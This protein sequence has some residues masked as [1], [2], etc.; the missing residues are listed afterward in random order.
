MQW[1]S[2]IVSVLSLLVSAG[3]LHLARLAFFRSG[4]LLRLRF[5]QNARELGLMLTETIEKLTSTR[6]S[7]QH[8]LAMIGLGRSGNAQIF[9]QEANADDAEL[10]QLRDKG[11]SRIRRA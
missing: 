4:A 3:S 1:A 7:H 5:R 9:E 6:Q 10:M 11:A 2:F 8:V